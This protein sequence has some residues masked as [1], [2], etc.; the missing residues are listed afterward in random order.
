MYTVC[1]FAAV[2]LI[3]WYAQRREAAERRFEPGHIE[4]E[5]AKQQISYIRQDV[6]LIAY[7]LMAILVILAII[8]DIQSGR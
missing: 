4:D 7:L 1:A 5:L 2:A 8:A 6:R 3:A